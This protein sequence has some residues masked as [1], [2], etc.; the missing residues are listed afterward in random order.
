VLGRIAPL[1]LAEEWD[2]VGLLVGEADGDVERCLLTIDLTEAVLEEA[3]GGAYGLIVA[4]HPPIFEPLKRVTDLSVKERIVLRALRKG[5]AF[6]SPHTALDAAEGGVNDWLADG[7]GAGKRQSLVPVRFG[8]TD[9]L[10]AVLPEE[11]AAQVVRALEGAGVRVEA[12][13]HKLGVEVVAGFRGEEPPA[14]LARTLAELPSLPARGGVEIQRLAPLLRFTSGQGREVTLDQPVDV[15][16]IAERVKSHLGLEHV[17]VAAA[18]RH[19]DGHPVRT[20]ALCAGAGGSVLAG[21]SADV[22]L[23]GEMRHHDVL[24]ALEH[25]TSVILCEHTNTERGY[26]P[27]LQR[28]LRDELRGTVEVRISHADDDPLQVV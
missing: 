10:C 21:R 2:N 27:I 19:L 14:V 24:L 9:K 15:G 12:K 28:R 16:T 4:Y 1:E 25:G 3:I 22:Y 11:H 7:L 13:S 6:Y 26:L 17:R 8:A 23:T 5:M 20:I 18:T